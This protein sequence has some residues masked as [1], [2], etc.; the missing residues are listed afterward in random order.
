MRVAV[1]VRVG[2]AVGVFV[3]LRVGL[4]VGVPVGNCVV[5]VEC[6]LNTI[7]VACEPSMD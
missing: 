3:D 5:W 1:G 6:I 7:S 2:V 4:G